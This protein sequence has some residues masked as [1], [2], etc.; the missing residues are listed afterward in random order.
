M[1]AQSA[2]AR[3]R[4]ARKRKLAWRTFVYLVLILYAAINVY[5]IIWMALNSFKT[6]AEFSRNPFGLPK[7]FHLDNYR[8]AWETARLEVYFFNSL[9]VAVAAVILTVLFGAL[10]AFVFARFP[11]KWGNGVYWYFVLGMLIPIH[12]TLVPMFIQERELGLLNTY[13]GII[14][15]YIAFNLPV[16]VFILTSF[17]KSFSKDIEESAVMDGCGVFRVFWKIILPMSGPALA[18]VVI[19]NFINNWNEF[20]FALV[21]I[22]EESLKTLP[23]GLANFSGQFTTNYGAQMA[24]LTLAIL[25]VII[26]YLFLEKYVV[27]GMTAGAVKG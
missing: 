23:L 9:F 27:K 15:P 7:T 6:N 2:D 17:M 12:A 1:A 26:I 25:P 18:T 22:N 8:I 11:F 20:S 10:A 19:L 21:L 5:P 14:L 24:G 13:A 16:T 4:A 3:N